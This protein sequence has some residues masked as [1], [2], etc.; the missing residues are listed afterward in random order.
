M[1]LA[2]SIWHGIAFIAAPI[3]LVLVLAALQQVAEIIGESGE[4]DAPLREEKTEEMK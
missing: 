1:M 2:A 4:S 3:V